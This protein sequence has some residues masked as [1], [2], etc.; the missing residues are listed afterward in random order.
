MSEH[1]RAAAEQ[2]DDGALRAAGF[3][4]FAWLSRAAAEE[5][6]EQGR[7]TFNEHS[8]A[9][10]PVLLLHAH[11]PE[12]ALRRATHAAL[13]ALEPWFGLGGGAAVFSGEA[14]SDG[15]DGGAGAEE[16]QQLL[17]AACSALVRAQPARLCKYLACAAKCIGGGH[18]AHVRRRGV[19][20]CGMILARADWEADYVERGDDSKEVHALAVNQLVA[21]LEDG[22]AAV[23]KEAAAAL[24]R[25]VPA[26]ADV[27]G[28]S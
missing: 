16:Q 27:G 5:P 6:S 13:R 15:A 25:A 11:H 19:A 14:F 8:H 22:D 7:A 1:S 2:A 4:T 12:P 10:L 28:A 9:L 20:L 17:D 21:A 3:E 23:R 26:I 18:D 24:G